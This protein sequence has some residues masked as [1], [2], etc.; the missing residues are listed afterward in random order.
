MTPA[1]G[2][3]P[4]DPLLAC[5]LCVAR[6]HGVALTAESATAGLPLVDH[7]LTPALFARAAAR[8][9]LACNLVHRPVV[10]LDH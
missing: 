2:S 5:L 4:A 9:D 8:A 10:D 7:R 3:W 1:S 6:A